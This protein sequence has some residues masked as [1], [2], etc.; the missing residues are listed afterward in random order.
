[1]LLKRLPLFWLFCACLAPYG[2]MAGQS[3]ECEEELFP[4]KDKQTRLFGYANAIGEM[5]VQPVFQR[6]FQFA[7]RYAIVQQGN[8]FGVINCEGILVVPADYEE[9]ASFT[10]GKGWVKKQNLWGMTDTKGR[11]LIAP[12]YEEIREINRFSGTRTWVKKQGLW[13]LMN[14]ENGRMLVQPKYA[15]VSPLSD[16]A[17]IGRHDAGQDLVYTGDGR[18][19]LA[20]MKKVRRINNSLFLFRNAEKKWGAFNSLAFLIIRPE[21]DNIQV[22]G[23]FLQVEKEGRTTLRNWR[24]TELSPVR[25]A[26]VKPCTDGYTAAFYD[27]KAFLLDS[28]AAS[29]LN[30]NLQDVRVLNRTRVILTR[31]GKD[32]LYNPSEKKWILEPVWNRILA[33]ADGRWL[34][35][36]SKDGWQVTTTGNPAPQGKFW[37]SVRIADPADRIRVRLKDKFHLLTSPTGPEGEPA[38]EFRLFPGGTF[39]CRNG[40]DWTWL[41]EA[42][43]STTPV[44]PERFAD[45]ACLELESRRVFLCRNAQGKAGLLDEKGKTLFPFQYEDLIPA[46]GKL[47]LVKDNGRWGLTDESGNFRVEARY[48]SVRPAYRNRMEARFPV[49]FFRKQKTTAFD[50]RGQADFENEPGFWYPA[51]PGLW[52]VREGG[53]IRLHDKKGKVLGEQ[54]FAEV[55]PFSEGTAAVRPDARWGYLNPSGRLV[56]PARFEEITPFQGGTAF[57]RENGKWGV[58]KRNGSWLI[59]PVGIGIETGD[60]GKRKLEMP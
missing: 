52:F 40:N 23:P 7:G 41:R 20:G 35:C 53:S 13:G 4:R 54:V 14:R 1:M 9:I 58:L 27:G 47:A 11:M 30:E 57:A 34:A 3:F 56:I 10:E 21:W 50:A 39:A 2:F 5:R 46:E 43:N 19:I 42:G 59:K 45:I 36:Q 29:V 18:V 44:T 25:Y 12:Q 32:G 38:D 51:M 48:D 49:L 28:R 22:N 16:S 8:R 55:M 31:D 6:A 15:D 17:A 24:G 33:S 37:D 26:S 60:D